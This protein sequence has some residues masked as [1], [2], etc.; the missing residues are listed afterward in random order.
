M[1]L[2]FALAFSININK[3][4]LLAFSHSLSFS[5]S[6]SLFLYLTLS[7]SLYFA[8][9]LFESI[10]SLENDYSGYVNILLRCTHL[11]G[12]TELEMLYY[13]INSA[14]LYSK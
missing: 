11:I 12:S 3:Y 6:L 14:T 10:A 1:L 4:F 13:Y 7:S 2:F 5:L 8:L 9:F